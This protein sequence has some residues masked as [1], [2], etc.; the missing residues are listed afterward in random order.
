VKH[1][2]LALRRTWALIRDVAFAGFGLYLIYR[3]TVSPGRN[4]LEILGIAFALTVPSAAEH[5]KAL[6]PSSGT[7]SAAK[8]LP[9]SSPPGGS[10]G[11][12]TAQ[13]E[14]GE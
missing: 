6:L 8:S 13:G 12:S 3:E 14:S 7:G 9:E 11:S 5:I 4:A 1:W 10:Q 2:E